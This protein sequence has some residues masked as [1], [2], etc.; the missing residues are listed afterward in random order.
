AVRLREQGSELLVE[1]VDNGS[2]IEP[3]L[4]PRL[5]EKYYRADPA[6]RS[7]LGLGLYIARAIVEAHGGRIWARSQGPG[8]G[9]TFGFSLPKYDPQRAYERYKEQRGQP[10]PPPRKLPDSTPFF[11]GL[12]RLAAVAAVASGWLGA[13]A[14][15]VG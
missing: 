3:E 8:R 9:A 10:T 11:L 14:G 12:R 7:S 5:F 13:A 1:V 6:T 4:L 15:R 2:G